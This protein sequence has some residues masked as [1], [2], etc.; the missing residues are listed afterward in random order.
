V[1]WPGASEHTTGVAT[2]NLI[3]RPATRHDAMQLS[4]LAKRVF[5][6]TYGSAISEIAARPFLDEHYSVA[7]FTNLLTHTD[8]RILVAVQLV[9][10]EQILGYVRSSISPLPDCVTI[11]PAL[12]L[13]QL[14]I[15]RQYHGHGIGSALLNAACE[16]ALSAGAKAIWLCAWEH[17]QRALRFY[18]ASGFAAVGWCN[19]VVE[20]VVFRDQIMLRSLV[21]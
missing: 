7:A 10:P 8:E 17:N 16:Y 4:V 6:H 2:N 13:A 18:E 3:I 19:V 21:H 12:E 1:H 9:R 11:T 5:I 15:E 14:Y 20:Q